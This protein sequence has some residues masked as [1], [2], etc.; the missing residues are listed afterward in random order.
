MTRHR[1]RSYAATGA[2]LAL[3]LVLALVVGACSGG[4][5]EP[6]ERP[7]SQP[8]GP[9]TVS[10]VE[11]VVTVGRITGS[12][13]RDARHRLAD[14]VGA[15]VDGWTKAA[16]LGGDYPRRDFSTSWPG[17]TTGARQ[18]AH[19]DRALMS[20]EDIGERIDGVEA[21]RSRVR[22]DVLAVRKRAVGVT[23][24]VLL[25][26][27]TTGRLERDIRVQGRLYLTRTDRGWRIFGYDMTKGA[28]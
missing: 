16:Y 1:R 3:A 4:D 10:K 14:Q 12:L 11:T 9:D 17:F 18:E 23:A 5:D 26:F 19:R 8:A 7:Q 21:R 2:A 28:R 22:I 20:N 24:R 25:G 15:V 13:P 6:A 27:R